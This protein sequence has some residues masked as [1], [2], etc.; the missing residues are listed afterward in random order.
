MQWGGHRGKISVRITH[1][2]EVAVLFMIKTIIFQKT[3]NKQTKKDEKMPLFFTMLLHRHLVKK[4]AIA[5][6]Q[7]P[8]HYMEHYNYTE[9]WLPQNLS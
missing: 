6:S 4:H 1:S 5:L 7:A 3:K 9:Q 8:H 2:S